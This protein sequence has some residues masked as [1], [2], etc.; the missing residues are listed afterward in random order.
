MATATI[1]RDVF[2]GMLPVGMEAKYDS[3]RQVLTFTTKVYVHRKHTRKDR[4]I[5]AAFFSGVWL[6]DWDYVKDKKDVLGFYVEMAKNRADEAL[7]SGKGY[8]YEFN[9]WEYRDK[10]GNVIY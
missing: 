10:K 4:F 6:S 7:K 3:I 2:K 9:A 1:Q 5:P 8:D